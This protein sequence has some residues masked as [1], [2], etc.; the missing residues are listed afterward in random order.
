MY[1]NLFLGGMIEE[2]VIHNE[3]HEVLTINK[4]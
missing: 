2:L 3:K 1:L 4:F